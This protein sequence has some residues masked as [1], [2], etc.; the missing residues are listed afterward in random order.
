MEIVIQGCWNIWIKR[1][2][3]VFRNEVPSVNCWKFKLKQGLKLLEH[4]IKA[5]HLVALQGWIGTHLWWS[6]LVVYQLD[7]EHDCHKKWHWLI[8]SAFCFS[9]WFSLY[10]LYCT[11]LF[12]INEK[13][14]ISTK[15]Q[16]NV[17]HASSGNLGS[18]ME[19]VLLITAA[20]T[21]PLCCSSPHQT[22]AFM[23]L[24]LLTRIQSY[25]QAERTDRRSKWS[26]VNW[27]SSTVAYPRD[28]TSHV[29]PKWIQNLRTFK[30]L[31][32]RG[33]RLSVLAVLS[34]G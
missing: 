31:F 24:L 15:A 16:S 13:I 29:R 32:A 3:K 11:I 10:I 5:N 8:L 34:N 28:L 21:E 19:A 22:C 26:P 23:I 18:M 27:H 33:Q 4:R 14:P 9:L 25:R 17:Q 12:L 30:F 6:A 1:N 7:F 2:G 20:P